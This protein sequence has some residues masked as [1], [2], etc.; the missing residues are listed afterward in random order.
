MYS[1][2]PG[3]ELQALMDFFFL[4]LSLNTRVSYESLEI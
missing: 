2:S 4:E 1:H 3:E